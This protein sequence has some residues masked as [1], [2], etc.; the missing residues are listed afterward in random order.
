MKKYETKQV[1]VLGYERAK[2]LSRIGNPK[3]YL[4][5]VDLEGNYLRGNTGNNG[6]CAYDNWETYKEKQ[7][8][9]NIRFHYTR[10]NNL[11]IDYVERA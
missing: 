4:F 11:I 3:Y 5:M 2:H 6:A 9:I 10:N 7:T 1:V 8:L